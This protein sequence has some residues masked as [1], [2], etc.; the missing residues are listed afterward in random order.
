M[1]MM[2]LGASDRSIAARSTRFSTALQGVTN[3]G[4]CETGAT[5]EPVNRLRLPRPLAKPTEAAAAPRYR[6]EDA[7]APQLLEATARD[8][9]R[10]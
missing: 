1:I 8:A 9:E 6:A 3:P 7:S 2:T 10:D 4:G 5:D